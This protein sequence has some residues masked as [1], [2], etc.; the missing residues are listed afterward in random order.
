MAALDSLPSDQRAVLELVLARGRSYDEIASLLSIDRAGVRARALAAL[1][2]LGPRTPVPA[3]RR[4]L[5]TDYLLGALPERVAEEVRG[6]LSQSAGE[7][8]WA[9]VVAAELEPLAARPLPPIPQPGAEPAAAPAPAPAADP[10]P[11]ASPPP[12]PGGRPPR[13]ASRTGGAIV[14]GVAALAVLAVVLFLVLGSGTSKRPSRAARASTAATSTP[15]PGTTTSTTPQI[16]GQVNLNP[17]SGGKAKGIAQVVRESGVTGV[18]IVAQGLAPNSKHPPNAYAVWLYNSPTDSHILGFVSPAVGA[19]GQMRTTGPFPSNASHYH[20]LLITLETRS[21]PKTPGAIV[22]Q[23]S[24]AGV[25]L[26]T[27]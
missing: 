5:I 26:T 2:A 27:G 24:L 19:N 15:T 8:A 17:P 23:G 12:R 21:N 25:P 3:E 6:H 11:A 16:L 18:L 14:L 9:R 4:A 10:V 13:P 20:K 7:R 22:L 1:D